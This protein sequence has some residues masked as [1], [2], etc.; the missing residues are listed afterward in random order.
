MS[1]FKDERDAVETIIFG[2]G[3]LMYPWYRGFARTVEGWHIST[4]DPEDPSCFT[5]KEINIPDLRQAASTLLTEGKYAAIGDAGGR[6]TR[7]GLADFSAG[8]YDDCDLDSDVADLIVQ[9]AL[10]GEVVWG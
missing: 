3:C 5:A 9:Q 7:L 4:D 1:I 10:Y 8:R 2:S 6:Y